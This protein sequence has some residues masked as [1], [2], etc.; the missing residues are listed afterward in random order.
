MAD[1][2]A[3]PP[4]GL[5]AADEAPPGVELPDEL[6]ALII[7]WMNPHTLRRFGLTCRRFYGL[8]QYYMGTTRY[9][10]WLARSML[11]HCSRRYYCRRYGPTAEVKNCVAE[12]LTGRPATS[13]ADWGMAEYLRLL[14][15][16]ALGLPDWWY[17]LYALEWCARH[18]RDILG[19]GGGPRHEI[20]ALL[21]PNSI[22]RLVMMTK[23]FTPPLPCKF[24]KAIK[25]M[26]RA[27]NNGPTVIVGECSSDAELLLVEAGHKIFASVI[28]AAAFACYRERTSTLCN[29]YMKN[30]QKEL[31]NM[32]GEHFGREALSEEER[33]FVLAGYTRQRRLRHL[34]AP[35]K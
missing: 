7:E 4:R 10:A 12:A 5:S 19:A 27:V 16:G 21:Y 1:T 23:R 15:P 32:P 6:I 13:F 14:Y 17:A 22:E 31:Y 8:V 30:L 25:R 18:E 2:P 33:W 3:S 9:P 28:A 11:L 26:M 34:L 29:S 24:G 20:L 35:R